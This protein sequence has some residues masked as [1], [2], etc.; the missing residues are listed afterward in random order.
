MPLWR[1][2]IKLL[3]TICKTLILRPY[4]RVTTKMIHLGKLNDTFLKIYESSVN[5]ESQKVMV[6]LFYDLYP[7]LI[8]NPKKIL[9]IIIE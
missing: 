2:W 1:E 7:K 5:E 3:K 4:V 9:G 8:K 6:Q